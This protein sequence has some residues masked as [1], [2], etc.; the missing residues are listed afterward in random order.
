MKAILVAFD[1][2]NRHYLPPYGNDWVKAPNFQR[3]A[4]RSLTFDRS[5]VCSMPCMP[6]RRDLQTGRPNFY[7]RPWGPME[8][9]D[10]SFPE[11][12]NRAGTSTHLVTDHYHY[13]EDGGCTYHSRY[14]TWQ[15]FRGQEGDPYLGQ[16]KDPPIPENINVKG[17]RHDWIN[18]QF[19]KE[20]KDWPQVQTFDAGLDFLQ[21]NHKDD[22][23]FLQIETFDPHEP[24]TAPDSYNRL[25]K[26]AGG[27]PLFDWPAYDEVKESPEEVQRLRHNYAALLSL[28]DAQLG[29]VLD[30]MDEHQ[31]WEDTLLIVWTDHGFLLGEHNRW[32]KNMPTMWEEISHTPFFIWD[33]R[34]GKRGER[35]QSLVQPSLDIAPTLLRFFGREPTESMTGYDLAGVCASDQP[36]RDAAVYGYHNLPIHVTDGRYVYMRFVSNPEHDHF[37]YTWM[38]T[39]MRG[40]WNHDKLRS[41]E[42]YEILPFSKDVPV[43]K[44]RIPGDVPKK[45]GTPVRH[46]L[47]DIQNDPQQSQPLEDPAVEERMLRLLEEEAKRSDAPREYLARYGL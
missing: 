44:F 1:S 31:L 32:A 43:P 15:C 35:R 10:D 36:V 9:W 28:C 22:G 12:L 11:I 21:R 2:L 33:P 34:C 40:F 20:E 23:W 3:L 5:Y 41:V 27:K 26:D 42:G 18:R 39:Q 14:D 25:Y 46:L 38:P 17:R 16:I 29:R 6:A 4:E 13:F 37:Q 24:F 8:P 30:A 19:L 45:S 7:H 47:F